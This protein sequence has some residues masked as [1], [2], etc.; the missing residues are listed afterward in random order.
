MQRIA[1][2]KNL[3]MPIYAKSKNTPDRSGK[4]LSVAKS[5]ERIAGK[6]FKLCLRRMFSTNAFGDFNYEI[7]TL[8][9]LRKVKRR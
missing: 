7:G 4:P 9:K 6:R 8:K 2:E 5:L 3:V 1:F